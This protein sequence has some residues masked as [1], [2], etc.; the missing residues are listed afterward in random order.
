MYDTV[1]IHIVAVHVENLRILT[2]R[3]GWVMITPTLYS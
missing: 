2:E 3:F 1:T